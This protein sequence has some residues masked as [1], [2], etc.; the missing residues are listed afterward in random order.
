MCEKQK[1]CG[2]SESIF[3]ITH[4]LND[5]FESFQSLVQPWF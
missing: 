5:E 4:S 2:G 1:E 3:D